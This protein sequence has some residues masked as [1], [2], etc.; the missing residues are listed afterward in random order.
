M[1][2]EQKKPQED[3]TW[4]QVSNAS[5]FGSYLGSYISGSS[6]ETDQ[7]DPLKMEHG[8]PEFNSGKRK[9][10]WKLLNVKGQSTKT[11]E[12]SLTYKKGIIIDE[13][14][15][16]K[17][18]PF[19]VDFDIPNHTASTIKIT[20]LDIQVT[21]DQM[22]SPWSEDASKEEV[23]GEPGKWVRHKTFSGSYVCRI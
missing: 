4:K 5:T 14:Q 6:A 1:F 11:L 16:K 17:L 20:R 23:K 7:I 8:I 21:E 2:Q 3:I 12:V 15:F 9:I 18:G 19:N 22:F 10:I 13:L